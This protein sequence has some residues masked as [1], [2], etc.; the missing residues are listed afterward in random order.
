MTAWRV[1]AERLSI[2]LS[3][4]RSPTLSNL[5]PPKQGDL[6]AQQWLQRELTRV[7]MLKKFYASCVSFGIIRAMVG[8]Y[9][10]SFE[11][12]NE[13]FIPRK[14]QYGTGPNVKTRSFGVVQIV[15]T[16]Q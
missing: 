4:N 8:E 13:K 9:V 10:N 15:Q 2:G 5:N 6:V 12:E 14:E 7:G 3:I 11:R 16:T 1:P